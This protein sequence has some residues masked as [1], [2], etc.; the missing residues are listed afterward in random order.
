L[1]LLPLG[2]INQANAFPTYLTVD[3]PLTDRL[4]IPT[5]WRELGA[6]IF[7]DVGGALRFELDVVGGL[8]GTGFAAQAPLAGGRGNGR[9]S[10]STAPR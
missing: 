8:N 1:L 4:I 7:G 6:G 10:P 3:R 2:I 9:T 5:I